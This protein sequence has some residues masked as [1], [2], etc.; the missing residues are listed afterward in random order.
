MEHIC[1]G[2]VR[3]EHAAWDTWHLKADTKTQ[4]ENAE[5]NC[6]LSCTSW[7]DVRLYAG[8]RRKSNKPTHGK[9]N[10]V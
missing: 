8:S 5:E 3:V 6:E 2:V 4:E 1:V 9:S 7:H 10:A